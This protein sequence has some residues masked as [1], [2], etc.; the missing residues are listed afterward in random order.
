MSFDFKRAIAFG[1]TVPMVLSFSACNSNNKN[2]TTKK[3]DTAKTETTKADAKKVDT[4]KHVTISHLSL[5][6]K[7]TNGQ[8]EAAK[9]EWDKYLNEKLNA[10]L[11]IQYLGWTDYM[12]KYNLLLATGEGLDLI[13]T[14]SDWLEMWP[15]AQKGAFLDIKKL[16]PTY[17]PVTWGSVP[18]KS[19]D[20]VTY[21]DGIIAIPEDMYTQWI[22]HGFMYRGDWAKEF[23]ITEPI[24]TWEGY[25]KYLQAVKDKKGSQGVVPFDVAGTS[26]INAIYDGWTISNSKLIC[27]D[28]VPNG[29]AYGKS[30]AEWWEVRS[31]FDVQ[32]DGTDMLLNFAKEMKKWGDA[33]YW[34][35]DVLNNTADSWVQFKAGL[36]GTRQHHTQTYVTAYTELEREIP[37]ANLKFFPW[38]EQSKNLVKMSITHGATAIAANSKNP[39]RALMVYDLIRNDEKM[40]KLFN[41]GI[42]GKQ[43]VINDKGQ[44][45]R[46]KGFVTDKDNF[47]SNFWGGRMDKFELGFP[48]AELISNWKEI[49][50]NFDSYA[51]DYKYG[52]FVFDKSP[53]ES[54]LSALSEVV[55]RLLP[56]IATGKAGDPEKAVAEFRKQLDMAGY[57]KVKT[58][59]QKQMTAFKATVK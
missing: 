42:E 45:D 38:S 28:P 22:N 36:N 24:K 11:E 7:P 40:Y 25:A 33:G 5:G 37:G 54:E 50:S 9:A 53:V 2:Q 29:L 55:T 41:W 48:N 44:K 1:L 59:V 56:A 10:D 23:G 57:K 4:S 58:E 15:N 20:E 46:P 43:Y 16:L 12:T 26:N 21:K 49:Y 17:A 51:T 52:K 8:Y 19:W 32:D 35:E 31:R 30:A 18:Q 6:N 27:I 3:A 14:A 34:R 47:A 13:N 39:E